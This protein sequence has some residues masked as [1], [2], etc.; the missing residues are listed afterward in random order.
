MIL[1]LV[2]ALLFTVLLF[3]RQPLL[4]AIGLPGVVYFIARDLPL[5]LV[6]QRMFTGMDVYL[7]LAIPLFALAGE[8]MNSG[9]L[10]D[11]L[12]DFAR[13]LVGRARGGL[14]GVNVLSSMFFSGI[15]G[16]GAADASATGSL[17]I[18]MMKKAG[19]PASFAAALTAVSA[20]V[21]PII[22]PSIVFIM[23]GALSRTSVADLFVAG[24]LPGVMMSMAHLITAL[25]I[26]RRRGYEA[27]QPTSLRRILRTG[28]GALPP[29]TIPAVMMGG[30]IFGI[31]TPTEAGALAVLLAGLLGVFVYRALTLRAAI[32]GGYRVGLEVADTM[33]IIGASNV[34]AWIL[35]V[36]KVPVML[37]GAVLSVSDDPFVVLLL[38]NL[39]LLVV[40]MFLDTFPALIILTSVLLPLAGSVGVEPVHFGVIV[41]L[42]LMI[43]AVTPPVGILLF[44]AN[45]IADAE[46]ADTLRE[47]MPFLLASFIVLLLVTYV[48]FLTTG[49]VSLVHP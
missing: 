34:L 40:G 3:S 25:W 1:L 32:R 9:R 8:L 17:L 15:T 31:V 47:L 7:L 23:Y 44:I 13:A 5:S 49:M 41:S 36:E 42:N 2:M 30:I 20:I 38:I 46:L 18:P 21:G 19:Y 12:V 14:A 4:V 33:L 22:P 39:I 45:R 27:G 35:T 16:S 26:S 28:T 29:L 11:R 10:T 43:G 37:A 24:V 6:A 48:P